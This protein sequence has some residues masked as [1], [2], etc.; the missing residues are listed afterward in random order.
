MTKLIYGEPKVGKT[1]FLDGTPDHC[2]VATEP[3]QDYVRS[4][5]VR[6]VHW[7]WDVYE[8]QYILAPGEKY[9]AP[10]LDENGVLWISFKDLVR[11]FY[12]WKRDG[13]LPY[14]NVS[15]DIV[16]KLHKLCLDAVC[17][18]AGY[19]YPPENDRG[20]LWSA[21]TADWSTWISKLMDLV[22]VSFVTHTT[23]DDVEVEVKGVKK[24]ITRR[25]P[26]FKGNKAAQY[27][28]GIVNCMG[29]AHFDGLGERVITF[30]GNPR[31]ATGDRS[32]V[33][34]G[35]GIMPLNWDHVAKTYNERAVEMGYELKSKWDGRGV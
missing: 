15:V 27:L 12:A 24:E 14:R 8:G 33:L 21:I 2:F 3:G 16:D 17:K 19:D 35:A 22:N 5:V 29:F 20:K 4:P 32:K 18:Q 26:T 10:R 13:V 30:A 23:S 11:K 28:D 7:G 31:L 34:E 9:I 6:I 1:T 25:I